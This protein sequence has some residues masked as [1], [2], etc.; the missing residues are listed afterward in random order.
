MIDFLKGFFQK[1]VMEEK[2]APVITLSAGAWNTKKEYDF[3]RYALEGY[4]RNVYV[5]KC[6]QQIARSASSIELN[7]VD[8]NGEVIENHPLQDLIDNPNGLESKGE[9]FEKLY[10]QKLIGGNSYAVRTGPS[11]GEIPRELYIIRPD[12]IEVRVGRTQFPIAYDHRVEGRVV[13]SYPVDQLTGQSDLKHFKFF[14]P[15]DDFLGMS[16]MM[17][18]SL[19]IDI[20]SSVSELN[21]SLLSNGLVPGAMLRYKPSNESGVPTLMTDEQM[22][23]IRSDF[24]KKYKGA[25]KAGE[26]MI[27]QGDFEWETTSMT[28]QEMEFNTLEQTTAK[29]IALAYGVPSQLIGIKDAQTYANVK[30]ARFAFY[31]ETVIPIAQRVEDDLNE[32]FDPY[33]EGDAHFK[34]DFD[35]IQIIAEINRE[36]EEGLTQLVTNGIISPNE[37]RDRIDLEPYEGGDQYVIPGNLFPVGSERVPEADGND[38]VED[39]T[40][41]YGER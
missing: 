5:F 23:Q 10:T 33:L 22:A 34:Y 29:K 28:P 24:E 11:G 6:V 12:Q 8:G 21:N 15:L 25:K 19:E 31:Q 36:R 26:L 32:W 16:P 41:A 40:A 7:I 13:E 3:R 27:L 4:Q 38:A 30:E 2:K 9:F 17:A 1:E 39:A 18:A 35:G 20:N 14:N 37:A